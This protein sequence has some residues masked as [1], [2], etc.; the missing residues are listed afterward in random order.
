MNLVQRLLKVGSMADSAAWF[1]PATALSKLIGLV[2]LVVIVQL[3]AKVQYNLW[4]AG[5][6]IFDIA[7][8]LLCLGSNNGLGRYVSVYEARGRLGEFYRRV[9]WALLGLCLVMAAAAFAGSDVIRV[10]A[11]ESE[12]D[13]LPY[14]QQIL[15]CWAALAN[16]ALMALYLNLLAILYGMRAYRLASMVEL[17]FAVLFSALGCG[18]LLF[19][20]SAVALLTA[21]A[22]CL[23]V[24]LGAAVA[25]LEV[26]LR[27]GW[28]AGAGIDAAEAGNIPMGSTASEFDADATHRAARPSL[29][30]EERPLATLHRVLSFGMVALAANIVWIVDGYL[31]YRMTSY[32]NPQEGATFQA[33]FRMDQN[34]IFLASAAYSVVF[35]HVARQFE[36]DRAGAMKSLELAFKAV[37]VATTSLGLIVYLA[38]PLWMHVLGREYFA[39]LGLV[40]P[41]LMFFLTLSSFALTSIVSRLNDRPGVMLILGLA[42]GCANLVLGWLLM[43]SLGTYGAAVAAGLGMYVGGGA[44]NWWYIR[45]TSWRP[46]AGVW[47]LLATPVIFLLTAGFTAVIWVGMCIAFFSRG[48][49]FSAEERQ[50]LRAVVGQLAVWRRR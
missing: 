9:K 45:K 26:A 47:L 22:A 23:V 13:N 3:L 17:S 46:G 14:S 5:A 21:H 34:V 8:P 28:V 25:V 19:W 49:L 40:G 32:Q 37:C 50:R 41:Q 16:A 10:L 43:P 44:V 36:E 1:I 27:K 30:M 29:P 24:V 42:G 2:R 38:A 6:M 39:G 7:A 12:R 18:L 4:G 33:F 35:S 20:P 15:A 11:I 48:G 31:S